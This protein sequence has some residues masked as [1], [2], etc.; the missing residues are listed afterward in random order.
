M[1]LVMLVNADEKKQKKRE[2]KESEI[3]K[4]KAIRIRYY[5]TTEIRIYV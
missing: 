3:D 2:K 5:P 4:Q 1:R